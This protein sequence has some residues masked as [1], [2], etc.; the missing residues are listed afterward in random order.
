MIMAILDSKKRKKTLHTVLNEQARGSALLAFFRERRETLINIPACEPE[1]ESQATYKKRL[2]ELIKLNQDVYD[3]FC[4]YPV[5]K[6]QL[7]HFKRTKRMLEL[8]KRD[9]RS[10]LIDMEKINPKSHA[11]WRGCDLVVT[12]D[13]D[14]PHK[15]SHVVVCHEKAFVIVWLTTR[16]QAICG[17]HIDYLNKYEFFH[18][19][20][21][22]AN[23]YLNQRIHRNRPVDLA[24]WCIAVIQGIDALM[25]EWM[26][27]VAH[28]LPPSLR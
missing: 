12:M 19:I 1:A 15:A 20:G 14:R 8:L 11:E 18:R 17:S 2:G 25:N 24:K 5:V 4:K 7:A 3:N 9:I 13:A 28:A 16:L 22:E 10:G 23:D 26:E 6:C 27:P 21:V